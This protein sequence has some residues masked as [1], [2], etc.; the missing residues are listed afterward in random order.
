MQLFYANKIEGNQANFDS[1]EARHCFQVLRKQ[2]GDPIQ[3][4]DGMG[5]F[6]EGQIISGNKNGLIATFVEKTDNWH[7]PAHEVHIAIAPTKSNDRFEW[8]LEKATEIGIHSITPLKCFNSER[9]KINIER[10]EKILKTAMKQ[11]LK[12]YL[13]KIAELT[14]FQQFIKNCPADLNKLIGYCGEDDLPHVKNKI[15]SR[16]G[17]LIVIGPEGDFSKEEFDLAVANG[18]MGI[19]LGKSRL[20]TET[21]AI[22]GCMAVA[23]AAE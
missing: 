10:W 7:T 2:I 1:N 13:P 17:N 22:Y 5:G 15:I 12:S 6:Y 19:S 8:F 18:F 23:L 20:R 14:D 4:V 11:S 9:R 16:E 21:A 3:F